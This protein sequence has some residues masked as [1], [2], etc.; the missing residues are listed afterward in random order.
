M[1][2]SVLKKLFPLPPVSPL[3]PVMSINVYARASQLGVGVGVGVRV[4]AGGIFLPE[5]ATEFD[6]DDDDDDE[7]EDD[8]EDL[9][10]LV[11]IEGLILVKGR[12]GALA[13]TISEFLNLPA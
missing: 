7:E 4:R 3:V 12:R 5:A 1:A 6:D 10:E 8:E 2:S 13:K 11:L 9:W